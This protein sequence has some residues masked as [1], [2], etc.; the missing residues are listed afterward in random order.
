MITSIPRILMMTM[1]FSSA[2]LVQA[3]L[4]YMGSSDPSPEERSRLIVATLLVFLVQGV[5]FEYKTEIDTRL[6]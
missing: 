5:C 3:I 1:S 6:I 2:F 4:R